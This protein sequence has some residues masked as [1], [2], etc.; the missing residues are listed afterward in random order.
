MRLIPVILVPMLL[1]GCTAGSGELTSDA[2]LAQADWIEVELATGAVRPVD[3]PDAR[4]LAQSRWRDGYLLFRRIP[5]ATASGDPAL[6]PA[7]GEAE[8]AVGATS[9]GRAFLAVFEL[10]TAQWAALTGTTGGDY[11]PVAGLAPDEVTT[12]LAG[13]RLDHLR[14]TLPDADLWAV[15]CNAGRHA[16]YAWGDGQTETAAATYA[17]HFPRVDAAPTGPSAVGSLLP[18]AYGLFD[19]HGN[20][21][22]MVQRGDGHEARGGAWD[23][24]V[25]QCR[26]ANLVTLPREA[27]VPNVGVRLALRP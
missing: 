2:T 12:V 15:G 13:V 11:L 14:L 25:M 26:T 3:E 17:V 5:A 19:T 20:V 24:P 23:S 4:A 18:N 1:A 21:W 16:L 9:D 7:G 8:D 10:T 22:E 6:L 27:R